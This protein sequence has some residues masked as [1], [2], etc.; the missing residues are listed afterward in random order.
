MPLLRRKTP[1]LL[2]LPLRIPDLSSLY[3]RK[4]MGHVVQPHHLVLPGLRRSER[5]RQSVTNSFEVSAKEPVTF[6]KNGVKPYHL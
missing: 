2:A 4:H 6:Y 5:F 1:F 3:A